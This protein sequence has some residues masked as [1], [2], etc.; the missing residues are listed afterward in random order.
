VWVCT[1]NRLHAPVAVDALRAGA[2]VLCE[3]PLADTVEAGQ[4]IVDAVV[5]TGQAFLLGHTLRWFPGLKFIKQA[6]QEGKL[7]VVVAARASVQGYRSLE[8]ARTDY[9]RYEKAA[10]LLDYAHETDYLRWY[11][12]EVTQ[13][14][15]VAATLGRRQH[16][17]SPNVIDVALQFAGG[18]IAAAHYDYV[19]KPGKREI[20]VF[21]D[22]GRIYYDTGM[23]T[24]DFCQ[25]DEGQCEKVHVK[26]ADYD[27]PY[28]DEI[29]NFLD[30]VDGKDAP[31]VT[32]Q[33]GLETLKVIYRIVESYEGQ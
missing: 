5:A 2:H 10:L 18:P 33:D 16:V 9:R 11:L 26:P 4:A 14:K 25:G 22:G 20:E 8:V 1:P 17:I 6:I 27:N 28:R 32:A 15:A 29:Q 23:D 12:G 3:K 13:V 24:L 31:V 7:G 19:V 21:G 30:A